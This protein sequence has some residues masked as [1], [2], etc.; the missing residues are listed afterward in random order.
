[1][2]TRRNLKWQYAMCHYRDIIT[3][4]YLQKQDICFCF[5]YKITN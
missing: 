5:R 4:A 2:C 1:M 3:P